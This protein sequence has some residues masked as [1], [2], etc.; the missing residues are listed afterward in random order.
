MKRFFKIFLICLY[1]IFMLGLN[2]CQAYINIK[3][4]D[5]QNVQIEQ[6][7]G[8]PCSFKISLPLNETSIASS[9]N[10]GYEIS[11]IKSDKENYGLAFFDKTI[12]LITMQLARPRTYTAL[13]YEC[14]HLSRCIMRDSSYWLIASFHC[15]LTRRFEHIS[16]CKRVLTHRF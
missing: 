7:S 9:N 8:Y 14:L 11:A 13:L 5:T 6:N 3:D 2:N 4:I 1:S 15:D 10:N 16:V 12:K